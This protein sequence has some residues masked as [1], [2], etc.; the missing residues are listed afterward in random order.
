[1]DTVLDSAREAAQPRM[2]TRKMNRLKMTK[3]HDKA[4]ESSRK[5]V[6]LA[7]PKIPTPASPTLATYKQE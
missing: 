4:L 1:M 3:S 7:R 5:R 6:L 2:E